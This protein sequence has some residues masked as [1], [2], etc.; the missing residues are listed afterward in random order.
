[1]PEWFKSS[2][3]RREQ[4]VYNQKKR[5]MMLYRNMFFEVRNI[6]GSTTL[7][8]NTLVPNAAKKVYSKSIERSVGDVVNR[9]LSEIEPLIKENMKKVSESV[10]DDNKEFLRDVGFD[11]EILDAIEDEKEDRTKEIVSLVVSGKLYDKNWTLSGFVK[12]ERDKIMSDVHKIVSKCL[13]EDMTME[14]IFYNLELYFNPDREKKSKFFAMFPGIK[15]KIFYDSVRAGNTM[16]GHSY[17]KTFVDVTINNPFIEAYRWITSGSDRVCAV[18]IDRENTDKFGLG[19]G[20]FPKD[21]LPLDHPNGMCTF[22][23]VYVMETGE[24][25]RE[26]DLWKIGAGSMKGSIDRWIKSFSKK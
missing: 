4:I 9:S 5:I 20:I 2:G 12:Q 24:I 21:K 18:C 3:K 17:E 14:E 11:D 15:R 8:K 26:V 10:V 25:I 19:I 6:F 16:V 1:M 23:P 7:R 13:D 22:D